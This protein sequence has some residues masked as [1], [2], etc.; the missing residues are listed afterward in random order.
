MANRPRACTG[1]TLVRHGPQPAVG[2][3]GNRRPVTSPTPTT[4]VITHGGS[5]RE[6][7]ASPLHHNVSTFP[8]ST[9]RHPTLLISHSY[10]PPRL[11]PPCCS[12]SGNNNMV[13]LLSVLSH[14]SVRVTIPPPASFSPPPSQTITWML[15]YNYYPIATVKSLSMSA[16]LSPYAT[17]MRMGSNM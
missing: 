3:S 8:Q 15:V 14:R 1:P 6:T 10:R 9:E 5:T 7:L 4:L 13:F 12:G 17:S 2:P 16:P 11:S